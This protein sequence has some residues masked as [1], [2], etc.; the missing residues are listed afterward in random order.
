MNLLPVS[1]LI[2][3]KNT[4][5]VPL[6]CRGKLQT[7]TSSNEPTILPNPTHRVN[8]SNVTEQASSLCVCVC[9]HLHV[10]LKYFTTSC[11][12]TRPRCVSDVTRTSLKL[13][14][15]RLIYIVDVCSANPPF[16]AVLNDAVHTLQLGCK[17]RAGNENKWCD[18][19]IFFA[20]C[21]V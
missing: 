20:E 14:C 17:L 8:L 13:K 16:R 11:C 19:I 15:R 4:Q 1:H 18:N 10:A 3:H 9:V 6:N 21:G 5:S 12:A 2:I 7:G